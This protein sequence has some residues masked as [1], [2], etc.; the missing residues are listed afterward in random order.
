MNLVPAETYGQ[1]PRRYCID[2]GQAKPHCKQSDFGNLLTF[3]FDNPSNSQG[4]FVY[5]LVPDQ[6]TKW[7]GVFDRGST[8]HF[9]ASRVPYPCLIF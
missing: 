1:G 9:L 5:R 7:R 3:Q 8:V 2:A 6:D 4:G